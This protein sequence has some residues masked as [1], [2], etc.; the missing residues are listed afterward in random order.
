M[1][2]Y[3]GFALDSRV[4]REARTLARLGHQ[5]EVLAVLE[6]G[7]AERESRDGYEI[8]RLEPGGAASRL[9]AALAEAR[10]PGPLRRLAL[11]GHWFLRW[12]RWLRRAAAAAPERQPDVCVAH[13]LD[14]LPAGARAARR[15][16]AP[17]IYD[18]HELFPDMAGRAHNGELER[19][20]WIAYEH[21]LIQRAD[22]VFAVT[23]SRAAEMS[24]RHGIPTPSVLR[25]VPE[26]SAAGERVPGVR[27]RAGLPEAT[28]LVLYLGMLQPGRGLERALEAMPMLPGCALVLMGEGE[29]DY[30]TSLLELAGAHG[31]AGS[32]H[33]LPPVRPHQVA[34]A[35]ASADVGLI[36][37]PNTA[38]NNYLS[39]PNKIFEY[40]AAGVPVVASDF[41]DMAALIDE[42]DVGETCDPE[43]PED[44]A[45]AVR[46]VLD[47]QR[48]QTALRA[49][50]KAAA[51]EL[52][53]D[54]EADVLVEALGLGKLVSE[55]LGADE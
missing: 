20:A 5:V 53:W 28:R 15:T 42:W 12:R 34:R 31:V 51:E 52:N 38:L 48:R 55:P 27:E 22:R 50:A 44:I 16:G 4:E 7:L 25:N 39:L 10:I 49:N 45:R 3:R 11:R 47:D 24:R 32:V 43:D 13:D 18:S 29:G 17:L 14:A 1:F 19:R 9:A 30:L 6:G 26:T 2:L 36:V 37:N 46:A 21:R 54:R 40:L 35:A 23:Q 33:L 41:P 8:R